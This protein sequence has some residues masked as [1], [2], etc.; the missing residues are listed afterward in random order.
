M[1][2][3]RA[4]SPCLLLL[5]L[6]AGLGVGAAEAA[7]GSAALVAR[8]R[9]HLVVERDDERC[10]ALHVVIA[11]GDPALTEEVVRDYQ[12]R[13]RV[14]VDELT[15]LSQVVGDLSPERQV[16]LARGASAALAQAAA[17]VLCRHPD[18]I[19]A[20]LQHG[21]ALE[22]VTGDQRKLLIACALRHVNTQDPLHRALLELRA[23]DGD[24]NEQLRQLIDVTDAELDEDLVRNAVAE[25][26]PRMQL[27]AIDRLQRSLRFPCPRWHREVLMGLAGS[28][29]AP[30]RSAAIN[31]LS[32]IA[33]THLSAEE[34]ALLHQ[35][36]DDP[37]PRIREAAYRWAA[38]SDTLLSEARLLKGL[39]DSDSGV[40]C[41][42]PIQVKG[43]LTPAVAAKLESMCA[44][45]QNY[46]VG[47]AG[48][49][50]TSKA[51]AADLAAQLGMAKDSPPLCI[52]CAM[53]DLAR[54][55]DPRANEVAGRLLALS[56][57]WLREEARKV[58][59]ANAVMDHDS[60]ELVAMVGDG[61]E[62]RRHLLE[63]LIALEPAQRMA[64]IQALYGKQSVDIK[65]R[66]LSMVVHE[67]ATAF[68]SDFATSCVGDADP[69]VAIAA[70]ETLASQA[71]YH[72]L[73]DPRRFLGVDAV[74][75]RLDDPD[76]IIAV[77]AHGFIRQLNLPSLERILPRAKPG[78]Q[79]VVIPTPLDFLGAAAPSA[80]TRGS[81]RYNSAETLAPAALLARLP[82]TAVDDLPPLLMDL[83][84]CD[85]PA[86]LPALRAACHHAKPAIRFSAH[87]ALLCHGDESD[88][89]LDF[90]IAWLAG[91]TPDRWNGQVLPLLDERFYARLS[92]AQG[93][94]AQTIAALTQFC[95]ELAARGTRA[96]LAS[97]QQ[98]QQAQ[99]AQRA[100]ASPAAW[101][102]AP[103]LGTD[104][105][106]RAQ[107]GQRNHLTRVAWRP[108]LAS[109]PWA[110][111]AI[112]HP[113]DGAVMRISCPDTN[114]GRSSLE[115]QLPQ[116]ISGRCLRLRMRG[117]DGKC[118]TI[119]VGLV[120]NQQ[121]YLTGASMGPSVGQECERI[122]T[123][124]R[125][126]FL[127][128]SAQ[129]AGQQPADLPPDARISRI[130][131]QVW[132][133]NQQAVLDVL[134]AEIVDHP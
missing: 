90:A 129:G 34:D 99:Q 114:R 8:L 119:S 26:S 42:T 45:D 85:D 81:T 18:Q 116:P 54:A 10:A 108:S 20:L 130:L 35:L 29:D 58:L 95:R 69:R 39:S 121:L 31:A 133:G 111:P 12:E 78:Q 96:A 84:A 134:D 3:A 60:G 33:R 82:T 113:Q 9:P 93:V 76:P 15:L 102:P 73:D 92:H 38:T 40:V 117:L 47:L 123:F 132:S 70:I 124:D 94:S 17:E 104:T 28:A 89:T 44:K 61:G 83:S 68:T 22:Q 46:I 127:P 16:A 43:A 67:D 21:G 7:D 49:A 27:A 57:P 41:W 128:A 74:L 91:M 125:A 77:A 87:M 13:A 5:A 126:T 118:D 59:S 105:A 86:V 100:A 72:Y 80:A 36:L 109:G 2:C 6:G 131:L 66:F 101:T 79:G 1:R 25:G 55:K 30:T 32:L 115:L 62:D 51:R 112:T 52:Y 122:F 19:V 64:K 14:E 110:Q 71:L 120:V 11:A 50:L 88:E 98:A 37:A 107:P 53:N 103:D 48:V 23:K 56:D 24:A 75:Q 97:A 65:L 4:R 63:S 106:P